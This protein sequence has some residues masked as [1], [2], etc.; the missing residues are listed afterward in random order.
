MSTPPLTH[1]N[2][3]R[4]SRGGAE[5]ADVVPFDEA[6]R[7]L[8]NERFGVLYTYLHRLSGDAAL[9]DDV[10]QEAFVRLYERGSMPQAPSAW[11]VSVAH[12]LV[13]DEHRRTERRRRLLAIWQEPVSPAPE[14]ESQLL[15][16]ER[17]MEVRRVLATLSPRHRQ[18]LLLRHGGHSYDEIARALG[19]APGSVG[20][21][22]VR[23]TAAFVAAYERMNHASD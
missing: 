17:A 11:L 16:G 22:L 7:A 20:T 18:L 6:F 9:A 3:R 2:L 5:H 1:A 12:N 23:A 21:L 10:A 8:F 15:L 19:V 14:P 13:R 4:P